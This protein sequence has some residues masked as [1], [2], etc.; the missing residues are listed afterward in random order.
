MDLFKTGLR[1]T[2][3]LTFAVA[4]VYMFV[5]DPIVNDWEDTGIYKTFVY[6]PDK[7]KTDELSCYGNNLSDLACKG[8]KGLNNLADRVRENIDEAMAESRADPNNQ[9]E[10]LEEC[11]A[12]D[13]E[14]DL[15]MSRAEYCE[16]DYVLLKN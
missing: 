12:S 8:V 13:K 15:N 5:V 7:S 14:Y 11:L 10:S 3:K 1:N 2:L 16:S 6:R 9:F 4:L